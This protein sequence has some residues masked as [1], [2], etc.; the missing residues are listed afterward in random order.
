VIGIDASPTLLHHAREADAVG[1][2]VIGDAMA[3]PFGDAAFD[4]VVAYNSL[5]D[6]DDM[7]RAVQE[8]ARVL[9]RGGR[10]CISVTH[11]LNDA[12]AFSDREPTAPFVIAGSYLEDRR[13]FE[14]TFEQDGY[15]I[16]FR[17]WCYPLEAY[18]KALEAAG[19]VIERIREPQ[20]S[21]QAVEAGG[22]SELRW[23]RVPLF[24]HILA[25]RG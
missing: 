18:A 5:M 6:V 21:N 7:P 3:L 17:G 9:D 19:F 13:R 24:L 22:G 14:A 10:F 23:R 11:P 1:G 8:S 12:G 2:Y 25:V 4:L 20:A 16:T 15:T